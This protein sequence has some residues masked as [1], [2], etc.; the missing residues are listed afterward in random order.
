MTDDELRIIAFLEEAPA[1]T[2]P[3]DLPDWMLALLEGDR[4]EEMSPELITAASLIYFRRLH[5]GIGL[6]AARALMAE[7]AADPARLADLSARI[8]AFRLACAFERLKRA[9][10]IEDVFI[11]DPFDPE[12]EV[13]VEL[14]EDRW[15]SANR[16]SPPRDAPPEWN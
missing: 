7:S 3:D 14:T 8:A 2:R 5:P 1:A 6:D 15:Q 13:S 12:A 11:D 4:P 10:R 9:G 16:E